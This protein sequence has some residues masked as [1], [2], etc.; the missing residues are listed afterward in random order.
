MPAITHRHGS[1]WQPP[2]NRPDVDRGAN[3]VSLS[4]IACL[5]LNAVDVEVRHV[6][7]P[8][9]RRKGA[10]VNAGTAVVEFVAAA[11]WQRKAVVPVAYAKAPGLRASTGT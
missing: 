2:Q 6:D 4:E 11:M 3:D 8:W 10:R 9:L 5:H 1:N 7:V